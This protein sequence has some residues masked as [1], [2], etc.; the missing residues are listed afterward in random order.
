MEGICAIVSFESALHDF[1]KKI[2]AMADCLTDGEALEISKFVCNN[3]A[4]ACGGWKG[5]QWRPFVFNVENER[6]AL[7]GFADVVNLDKLAKE[8]KISAGNIAGLV[9]AAYSSYGD[10][11]ANRLEGTFSIIVFDKEKNRL[12]AIIDPIGIRPLYWYKNGNTYYFSSRLNAIKKAVPSLE[13]DYQSVYSFMRYEMI[14]APTTIYKNAYKLEP[15]TSLVAQKETCTLERYWDVSNKP[16]LSVRE[17][18]ASQQ[19]YKTIYSSL[20][21]MRNDLADDAKVACFLSGGTD[22]SSICGLLSKMTPEPVSAY[23]IGFPENG[24]DEMHYAR[25]AAQAFDL[26]HHEFYV[27]PDDVLNVLPLLAGA[28]DEPFGNSSI[29][30]AYFCAHEAAKNDVSYLLAGDGGDEVFG[31]NERYSTQ[32]VFRNYF[33][34]P[35]FFRQAFL[36]PLLL[37]RLEKLPLSIF[38]K[39]GSYI[40]RAKMPEAKRIYSYRYIDDAEMFQSDFLYSINIEKTENISGQHFNYLQDAELLD[41]HLYLDMKMTIADNDIVKVTRM[42]Q[43]AKVRVRYPLLDRPVVELGF[44]LPVDL[45]LRGSKGLRYI[46]KKAFNDLLPQEILDKKKHGFGL[47]VAVWLRKDEKI[48]TFA[49]N[50][51]FDEKHLQRGYFKPEFLKN[52]WKMQLEDNTSYYG[53]VVWLIIMLEAWHRIHFENESLNI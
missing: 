31:G 12:S 42:C 37:N 14:P 29:I 16:K 33:K 13:I 35:G 19:V 43:L 20:A 26:D 18:E 49:Y 38:Q 36:E 6:I 21:G 24:Y 51:L 34:L 23:S 4:F 45:K 27:T 22:S 28:Y 53:S 39:A 7:V 9:A 10:H 46:F 17:K 47:P 52:L 15:G 40:R 1:T 3:L 32:Q 30:P 2:D 50:L 48:R 25:I 41:R 5:A 11:W 8:F 44:R